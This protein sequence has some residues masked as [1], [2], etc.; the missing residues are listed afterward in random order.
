[1]PL[2]LVQNEVTAENRYDHWEDNEGV[3]YHFPNQYINKIK[4]GEFFIY[5]RG[6]RRLSKKRAIPEYFG[7]GRIGK[8]WLDPNSDIKAPKY[9]WHWYCEI[10]D[11][12][13]FLKPIP[14]KKYGIPYESIAS[15]LWSVAVRNIDMDTYNKILKEASFI[16]SNEEIIIRPNSPIIPSLDE[17]QPVFIDGEQN[18]MT[19]YNEVALKSEVI[20]AQG[21]NYSKHSKLFGDRAE[22]I[23]YQVLLKERTYSLRWVAKENEKPGWD[24]EY[25][26]KN[27]RV[28]VEVKGT[29]GKRFLSVDV[30]KREWEAAETHGE[31]YKLYLV[32]DCLSKAPKIQIISNPYGLYLSKRLSVTPINYRLRLL[33]Q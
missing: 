26:D 19:I 5:Y 1:M 11:Y 20:S 21:N 16:T 29:S 32:A 7:C 2:V 4:E 33:E 9:T 8:V 15:N 3:Q 17:I 6:S 12:F 22:E 24:I 30:T 28:S 23:V 31:N 13:P 14:F 25:S 10:V 18:L 27:E